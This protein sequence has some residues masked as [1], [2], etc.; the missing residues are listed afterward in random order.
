MVY[1]PLDQ[2]PRPHVVAEVRAAGD[3]ARVA[4][5]LRQT[6]LAVNSDIPVPIIRRSRASQ[7]GAGPRASACNALFAVDS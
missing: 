7:C 6:M 1:L 5:A 4:D 2:D 3:I